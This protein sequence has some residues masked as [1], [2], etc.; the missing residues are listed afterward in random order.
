MEP[1]EKV[2]I[3]DKA[4]YTGAASRGV[5]V[6]QGDI[7]IP[8][9]PAREPLAIETEHF[10]QCVLNDTT[11]RSDGAD[12]LRVVR[13]LEAVDRQLRHTHPIWLKQAA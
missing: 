6:R 12:G 2:R 10:I 8:G 3:F 5:Q 7:V 9:I 11:P 13:V 4:A 1:S